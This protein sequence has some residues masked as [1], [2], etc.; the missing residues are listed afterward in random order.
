MQPNNNK[1]G[2]PMHTYIVRFITDKEVIERGYPAETAPKCLEV[3]QAHFMTWNADHGI[4]HEVVV[5]PPEG[6]A[7]LPD[8]PDALEFYYLT[9]EGYA[10]IHDPFD[11]LTGA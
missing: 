6:Q 2:E 4:L 5:C 8:M 1:G 10:A 11:A 9:P 3:A 7:H